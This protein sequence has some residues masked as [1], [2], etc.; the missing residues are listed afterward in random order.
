MAA[1]NWRKVWKHVRG[2][3]VP[4]LIIIALVAGLAYSLYS[5]AHFWQESDEYNL[6]E[7]LNESR[8]FRPTLPDLVRQ[9]LKLQ[10]LI[11]EAGSRSGYSRRQRDLQDA[12]TYKAEE[13]HEQLKAL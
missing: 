3:A 4:V 1:T 13:I 5:R 9:Y 12:I 8:N 6:R 11:S 10:Q 7:W 2:L